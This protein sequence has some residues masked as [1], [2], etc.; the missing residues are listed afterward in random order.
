MERMSAVHFYAAHDGAS[1]L[2]ESWNPPGVKRDQKK[3][4]VVVPLEY[5]RV[6]TFLRAADAGIRLWGIVADCC[7]LADDDR[8][9]GAFDAAFS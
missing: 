2:P 8:G 9:G 7:I 1:D 3:S 6:R 5:G 4:G